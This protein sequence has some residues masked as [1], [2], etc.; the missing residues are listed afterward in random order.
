MQA[1]HFPLQ[2][3]FVLVHGKTTQ[4]YYQEIYLDGFCFTVKTHLHLSDHSNWFFGMNW[5]FV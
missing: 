2:D 4:P 5:L 1:L 3:C